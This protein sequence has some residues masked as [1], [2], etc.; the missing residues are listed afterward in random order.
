MGSIQFQSHWKLQHQFNLSLHYFLKEMIILSQMSYMYHLLIIILTINF[1]L[2]VPLLHF[3]FDHYLI[4]YYFNLKL[5][6]IFLL[7]AYLTHLKTYQH[8]LLPLSL[9]LYQLSYFTDLLHLHG[10]LFTFM[11]KKVVWNYLYLFLIFILLIIYKIFR[12]NQ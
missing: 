5:D 6:L 10:Q 9:S 11:K 4:N 12:Y 1:Y 3:Y 8:P 2:S 7:H